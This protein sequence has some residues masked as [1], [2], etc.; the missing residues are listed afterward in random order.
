MNVI[1]NELFIFADFVINAKVGGEMC[2][3]CSIISYE[4][5]GVTTL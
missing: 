4:A 2:K 5:K 1:T 3:F